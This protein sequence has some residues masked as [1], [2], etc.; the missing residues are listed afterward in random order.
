[1]F[2]LLIITGSHIRIVIINIY[3][4]FKTMNIFK[5]AFHYIK[6]YKLA[7]NAFPKSNAQIFLKK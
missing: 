7:L 5:S 3:I 2:L 1:M 4:A 6:Y